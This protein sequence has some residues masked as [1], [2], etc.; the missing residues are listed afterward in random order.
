MS[1]AKRYGPWAIIAGASE[2][3]GAAYARKVAAE[4]VNCILI[5][6]RKGPLAV[7]A[8]EIR[9]T[10]D[11]ECVTL[12]VD[13]SAADA[14]DRIKA[15]VGRR[16]VGL[17]ISNAGADPNGSHFLNRD[18]DAWIDL[19]NRNIL[20]S[21][22]CCHHFGRLMRKRGRGGILLG[23]SGACYG[24]GPHLATYSGVKAFD[25][26]FSEGL[27]SELSPHGVDVLY[28]VMTTTDTPALRTLLAEKGVPLPPDVASAEDVAET[29]LTR[30]P[31][32]PVHNWGLQDDE[33]GYAQQGSAAQRR[34]RVKITAQ[35]S[36]SVFGEG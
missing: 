15:A 33:A 17:Y 13:L 12:S 28:L 6:R 5:A 32:G 16:E 3:T 20:T 22:R 10:T 18:V 31:Y 14:F 9:A 27:W 7:L 25:L 26:C 2:G 35:M 34:A 19:I 30:L 23:G 36:K 8:K 24:G 29:G 21:V 11:V 1:F 4:G